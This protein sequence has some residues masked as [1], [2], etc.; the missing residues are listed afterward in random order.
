[1]LKDVSYALEL[2]RSAGLDLQ[3]GQTARRLLAET[4][5][6]GLGESYHTAVIEAVRWHRA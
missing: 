6:L 1:M 2:A 5:R 4:Q 3:G